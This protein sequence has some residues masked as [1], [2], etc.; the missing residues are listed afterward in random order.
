M[1][2][3]GAAV[4][5][6]SVEVITLPVSDVDRALRFYVDRVGFALDV[7]YAPNDAFR[8][9]TGLRLLDPDRQ[10]TDRCARRIASQH[11]SRRNRPR[12]GAES[13]ARTWGRGQCDPTQGPHRCL[14]RRFRSR[15]RPRAQ[16]LRELRR[17]LGPGWQSLGA[18]GTGLPKSV[19]YSS[20][21]PG[22]RPPLAR[23]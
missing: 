14:G 3:A 10:G 13:P 18:A 23:R 8:V 11:L 6:F 19:T 20:K 16:G 22:A 17:L 21:T 9:A 15:P 5:T 1:N 4:M 12:G 2:A 7:D